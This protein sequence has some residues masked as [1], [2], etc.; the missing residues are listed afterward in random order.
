[1]LREVMKDKW[2]V[3]KARRN[4][5]IDHLVSKFSPKSPARIEGIAVSDSELAWII[6]PPEE[7]VIW[8]RGGHQT[9][10]DRE[11]QAGA[12]APSQDHSLL[13]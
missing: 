13:W 10:A 12:S 9:Q 5:K 2:T 7:P 3:E 4:K 8:G 1:M 11:R 6:T